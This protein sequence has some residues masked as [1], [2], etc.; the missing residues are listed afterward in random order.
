MA[1]SGCHVV[2]SYSG[3]VSPQSMQT[4]L[5]GRPEWSET[6]AVNGSAS[7][8]AAPPTDPQ[9]KRGDP[10]FH[11]R[12]AVDGYLII[13]PAPNAADASQLRVVAPA[14]ETMSVYVKKGDKALFVG[15]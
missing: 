9:G 2:C 10:I 14:G 12:A 5:L 15:A 6:L 13:D 3:S 1:L 11:Y 7:A 4:S 8:K